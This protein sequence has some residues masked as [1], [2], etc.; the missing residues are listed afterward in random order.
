MAPAYD[1]QVGQIPPTGAIVPSRFT[2]SYTATAATLAQLPGDQDEHSITALVDDS[3]G[4]EF[5]VYLSHG[6]RELE[7]GQRVLA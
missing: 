4:P 3:D 7:I 2:V 5:W 1:P 6:K